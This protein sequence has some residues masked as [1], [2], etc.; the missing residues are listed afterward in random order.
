MAETQSRRSGRVL[1]LD[2]ACRLLLIRFA[3]ERRDAPFVFWASPGGEV[4]PGETD[5]ETACRELREE[6][7]LSIPLEGPV[8]SCTSMF[9]HD[10]RVVKSTDVFFLGRCETESLSLIGLTPSERRAMTDLRWWTVGEL[11]RTR[12]TV[13]PADL[14]G[15]VRWLVGPG[16]W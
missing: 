5:R 6:L 10:G 11:E 14:A 2:P 4:E 9:E 12:E 1:L 7:G 8:H 15:V 13:F 3:V 16:G